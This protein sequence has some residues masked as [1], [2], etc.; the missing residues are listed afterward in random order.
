MLELTATACCV[1]TIAA[2]SRSNSFTLGPVVNLLSLHH[3]DQ[4]YLKW[5]NA[6]IHMLTVLALRRLH[7]LT[8]LGNRTTHLSRGPITRLVQIKNN[9]RARIRCLGTPLG[10]WGLSTTVMSN[11][12]IGFHEG[13]QA[14]YRTREIADRWLLQRIS[15]YYPPLSILRGAQPYEGKRVHH[16]KPNS[17]Y[18]I[19]LNVL[20]M[21]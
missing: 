14:P 4:P 16:S 1:P 15:T 3:P 9:R 20:L 5:Q 12:L 18:P 6:F 7:S 10:T 17:L 19:E 21:L 8:Q 2:N 13:E 11:R